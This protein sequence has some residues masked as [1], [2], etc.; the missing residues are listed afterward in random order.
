MN[1]QRETLSVRGVSLVWYRPNAARVLLQNPFKR[2]ENNAKRRAVRLEFLHIDDVIT[3][4]ETLID[5][6]HG[7]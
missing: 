1:R 7:S 2:I 4:F 5:G 6:V 3:Q